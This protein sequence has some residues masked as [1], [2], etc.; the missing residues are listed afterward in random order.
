MIGSAGFPAVEFLA[1]ITRALVAKRFWDRPIP[2]TPPGDPVTAIGAPGLVDRK[3][4]S[5]EVAWTLTRSIVS[6]R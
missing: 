3:R 1:A 4:S 2:H 6:W 5:Q